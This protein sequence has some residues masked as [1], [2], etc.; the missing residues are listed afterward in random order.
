MESGS[1]QSSAPASDGSLHGIRVL[2][3]S[4]FIA[5]PY[6]AMMLGDMGADVL[7]IEKPGLGDPARNYRPLLNG[8]STYSLMFNRNKRSVGLDLRQEADLATLRRLVEHADILI[9]NFRPG[10]MEKMGLGWADLHKINPRLIMVRISGFGQDGPWAQYPAFDGIAQASGGLME[11]TGPADGPPTLSGTYVCDYSAGLYAAL[12]AVSAINARHATGR[13]QIVDVA[14]LDVAASLLTST[15]VEYD[16][17]GTEATRRGSRDRYA[18]PNNAYPAND[19]RWVYIVAGGPEYFSRFIKAMG[20][21]DL[22]ED[23]RFRDVTARRANWDATEQLAAEWIGKQKGEDAVAALRE[24]DV[25]CA[26]VARIPDVFNNPQLRHRGQIVAIEDPI[27]GRYEM[28]GTTIKLSETPL[29]IRRPMPAVG[30][31][32]EQAIAEWLRQEAA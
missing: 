15:L 4:R 6:C 8:R 9:E 21:P 20:R 11:I 28:Q 17:F 3:L 25:P 26:L 13:G 1:E 27:S 19:G 31:H 23:P 29:A 22:A 2:D 24:S 7:K 10:V 16:R 18:S 14:L 5:G 12:G 32:T 30:E